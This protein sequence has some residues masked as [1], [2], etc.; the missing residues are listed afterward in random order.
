MMITA[1]WF[2]NNKRRRLEQN[3]WAGERIGSEVEEYRLGE[4]RVEGASVAREVAALSAL[5]GIGAGRWHR[6]WEATHDRRLQELSRSMASDSN[7]SFQRCAADVVAAANLNH[8]R[9]GMT[10]VS[11]RRLSVASRRLGVTYSS[12]GENRY[13]LDTSGVACATPYVDISEQVNCETAAAALG[14]GD[15]T[16]TIDSVRHVELCVLDFR[17]TPLLGLHLF[18]RVAPTLCAL[19]VALTG[20]M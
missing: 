13:M 15:T 2:D 6:S 11:R 5:V 9:L 14:I 4:Y 17:L 1:P 18:F 16:A 8:R 7:S 3:G 19:L 20:R 10:A 12:E